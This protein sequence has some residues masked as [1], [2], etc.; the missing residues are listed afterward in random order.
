MIVFCTVTGCVKPFFFLM[1]G[2]KN[3]S[4]VY[5]LMVDLAEAE[6][7]IERFCIII[8]G[9]SFGKGKLRIF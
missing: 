1:I 6:F 7:V 8:K 3:I 2:K 5:I 4:I 9:L